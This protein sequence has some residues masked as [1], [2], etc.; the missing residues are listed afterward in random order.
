MARSGQDQVPDFLIWYVVTT[1]VLMRAALEKVLLY[2]LL[3]IWNALTA[4]SAWAF[5]RM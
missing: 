3:R 4:L 2:T 1:L 5:S